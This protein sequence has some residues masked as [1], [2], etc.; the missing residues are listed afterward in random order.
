MRKRGTF[1]GHGLKRGACLPLIWLAFSAPA[2]AAQAATAVST[3][4]LNDVIK[5]NCVECHNTEEWAGS[6]ALDTMDLS[7]AGKEPEVWE[8]TI[9]KLRGRLMPPAGKKQPSQADVDALIGFLETSIDSATKST[10][11]GHV[12][13]QRLSRIEFAA[14]VKDLIGVE[15]DARQALP[16]EVEVE[17]FSNIASALGVSPS[18]VEQYISATRRAVKLAIGDPVPRMAKVTMTASQ[19]PLNSYPLGTRGAAGGGGGGAF[20]GGGSMRFTYTFPADGEYHFNITEEDYIGMGLYPRG[21]ENAATL[22]VLLDGVEVDRKTLGGGEWLDIADRDGPAGKKILLSWV[23]TKANVTAGKHEVTMTYIERSRALGNGAQDTGRP[24]LPGLQTAVEIQGPFAPAGRSMNDA[25][26]RIFTC[27]PKTNTEQRPCADRIARDFATRAYRRPVTDADVTPLM[28]FYDT[29]SKEAGGFEA[30]VTE[31]VIAVLSS[32]DFLYRAIPITAKTSASRL[33]TD[34]ELATRLSFFLWGVGPDKQLLDLASSKQ[35]SN[36]AVIEAQVARML[37]DPRANALVE[38]FALA[39]LNLDELE[40]VEPEN[41]SAAMRSNYETEIRMFVSSVLLEE[42]SVL[43]L[44]N[45]NWTFVNES[46]AQQYGVTGVKGPTFRRITLTDENRYGILGKGA[47]LLRTSYSGRT[48]PVLRGAWVLDKLMGT[49]PA[50]PP[51]NVNTDIAVKD[52]EKVTTVRDRLEVHRQ[53]PNCQSCHGIIDPPG[54]ALENF[55]NQG[56]WRDVDIEAGRSPIDP[57]TELSS[58]KKLNGPVDLRKH[59]TSHPDQLPTTLTKRLM[60]FALNREIE[61]FDMPAVRKI[62]SDAATKNYSF[63]AIITGVVNS[64]AFRLQ[65][66]EEQKPAKQ[67]VAKNP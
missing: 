15:V 63:G 59:L 54:L 21:A 52:G 33:L 49:P 10:R 60:M 9:N 40:K 36:P 56:R 62:V 58:G 6:L 16:T 28:K 8:N 24:S 3:K 23:T 48:S 31:M 4:A 30:G 34:A 14:S 5:K 43:D 2:S 27:L 35:L 41:F 32:P 51:P 39:W 67:T 65:A 22:I 64:D 17:G 50:P 53:A 7:H 20:G 18:F 19:A 29:G 11:V 61:Y 25:R 13:V 66:P 46:L 44:I 26:A 1:I 38:N 37:K 45:A 57:K 47:M 12:P 42:R 55:D